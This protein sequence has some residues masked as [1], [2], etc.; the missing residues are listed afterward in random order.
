M[1]IVSLQSFSIASGSS[2]F[3]VQDGV[4]FNQNKSVLVGYP[5]SAPAQSYK[6]PDATETIAG[7]SFA[8]ASNLKS[9]TFSSVKSAEDYASLPFV[10]PSNEVRFHCHLIIFSPLREAI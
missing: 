10:K 2:H 5:A 8:L 7:Y 9:V 6:S 3:V 4:L 1:V